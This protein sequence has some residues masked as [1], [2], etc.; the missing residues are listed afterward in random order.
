MEIPCNSTPDFVLNAKLTRVKPLKALKPMA[1]TRKKTLGFSEEVELTELAEQIISE[2]VEVSTIAETLPE[3][4][5]TPKLEPEPIPEPEPEPKPTPE[6][7]PAPELL[8]APTLPSPA[9]PV[10]AVKRHPRNVPKFAA[11][12]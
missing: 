4:E 12:K 8:P 5:I 1:V 11:W 7:T 10:K 6:P 2:V 9:Q 3:V